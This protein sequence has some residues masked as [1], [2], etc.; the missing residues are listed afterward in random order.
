MYVTV[1]ADIVDS[2]VVGLALVPPY[3]LYDARSLSLLAVQVKTTWVL[4]ATAA[5][6][7]GVDGAVLSITIALLAPREFVA[8]GEARVLVAAT[9]K[10]VLLMVPL[11]SA[12]AVVLA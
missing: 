4:P 2:K 3:T 1:P 12:S 8:P 5:R 6:L 10:A 9:P 7:L 11:L